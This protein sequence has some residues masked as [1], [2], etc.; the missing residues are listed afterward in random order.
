MDIH[1]MLNMKLNRLFKIFVTENDMRFPFNKIS[2]VGNFKLLKWLFKKSPLNKQYVYTDK[3][4]PINI[5]TSNEKAFR[6]THGYGHFDIV[7][8]LYKKVYK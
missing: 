5:Y 8:W 3:N 4:D 7:K 2:D 6:L 1:F